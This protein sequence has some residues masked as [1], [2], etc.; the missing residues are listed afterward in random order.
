DLP[1]EE[2]IVGGEGR[3]VLPG[4]PLSQMIGGL[5]TAIREEAPAL[6]VKLGKLLRQIRAANALIVVERKARV[7][8]ANRRLAGEAE[9]LDGLRAEA[10][11][12]RPAHHDQRTAARRRARRLTRAPCR[13]R[14]RA[15]RRRRRAGDHKSDTDQ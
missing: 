4:E 1:G 9:L 13:R 11:N 12:L 15:R 2:E 6:G 8:E 3:A 10:W 14:G 5:H 7:E